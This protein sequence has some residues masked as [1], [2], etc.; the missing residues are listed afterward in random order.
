[1]ACQ[2]LFHNPHRIGTERREN[3]IVDGL[4][5]ET[6][7]SEVETELQIWTHRIRG[8]GSI[9]ELVVDGIAVI[10]NGEAGKSNVE[11]KSNIWDEQDRV[12]LIHSRICVNRVVD[13]LK[14]EMN[15]SNVITKPEKW[16]EHDQ[17]PQI[18]LQIPCR[19]RRKTWASKY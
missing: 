6:S 11:T 12:R 2:E 7:K 16:Y 8:S 10:L 9:F 14:D 13:V 1:M 19:G 4:R 17:K 3:G 5:D 15:K 18:P